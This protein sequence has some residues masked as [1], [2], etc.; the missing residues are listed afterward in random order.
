MPLISPSYRSPAHLIKRFIQRLQRA[1]CIGVSA[2]LERVF[3]L[4]LQQQ[5]DL[6][7]NLSHLVFVHR[8]NMELNQQTSKFKMGDYA[9]GQVHVHIERQESRRGEFA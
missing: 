1:G 6:N 4:Q 7:Q 3:A 2:G 5:T 9:T 8:A